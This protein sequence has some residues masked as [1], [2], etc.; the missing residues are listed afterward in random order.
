M[1]KVPFDSID[2]PDEIKGVE[3]KGEHFHY[4]PSFPNLL[5]V[6]VDEVDSNQMHYFTSLSKALVLDFGLKKGLTDDA[7]SHVAGLT[8]VRALN[9]LRTPVT[10]A[11]IAHLSNM[12]K[13]ETLWLQETGITGAGLTY[14]SGMR[15]LSMLGLGGTDIADADLAHLKDLQNLSVL[16]LFNTPLTDEAAQCIIGLKNLENLDIRSTNISEK[17]VMKL[18][19]ALPGCEINI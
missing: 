2:A 12:K 4:L 14:L 5:T 1:E 11:G 17:E 3:L 13:M 9:L 18:K 19:Q 8:E 15:N 10:D 6:S 7:L 16:S